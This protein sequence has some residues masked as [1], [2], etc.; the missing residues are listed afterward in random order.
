MHGKVNSR[1]STR[2]GVGAVGGYRSE[3]SGMHRDSPKWQ[4][5]S[6]SFIVYATAV[7]K[8]NSDASFYRDGMHVL[9]E[10]KTCCR[11]VLLGS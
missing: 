7:L 8:V 6:L 11:V 9:W 5:P 4:S 1:E 2:S 3:N 10:L